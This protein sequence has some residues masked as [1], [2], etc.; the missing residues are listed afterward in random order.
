MEINGYQRTTIQTFSRYYSDILSKDADV[1]RTAYGKLSL[2]LRDN[3]IIPWKT[4]IDILRTPRNYNDAPENYRALLINL[5]KNEAFQTSASY[6]EK[7]EL[8]DL[9]TNGD[10]SLERDQHARNKYLKEGALFREDF[11]RVPLDDDNRYYRNIHTDERVYY[12]SFSTYKNFIDPFDPTNWTNSLRRKNPDWDD[13]QIHQFMEDTRDYGALRGTQMHELIED[14]LACRSIFNLD[15]YKESHSD[16]IYYFNKILPFL[17][18]SVG[19]VIAI[20]PFLQW[21]G[22]PFL[23]EG[24]GIMGYADLI[25]TDGKL[26]YLDDWKTATK[27]K[28]ADYLKGYKMQASI[29]CLMAKQCLGIEVDVARIVVSPQ[30][31]SLQVIELSRDEIAFWIKK[32][33][34]GMLEYWKKYEIFE[35]A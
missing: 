18:Y 9:M 35:V 24:Q 22:Q 20:E 32:F 8:N 27:R 13:D 15:D 17:R 21:D 26:V 5:C 28:S 12:P 30:S 10:Y 16:G 11:E 3:A 29:Y 4:A 1:A 14:Y 33:I 7:R 23:N 2:A 31:G 6:C 25:S 34:K 19:D